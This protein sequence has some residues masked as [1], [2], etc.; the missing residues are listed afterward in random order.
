[1]SSNDFLVNALTLEVQIVY[2]QGVGAISVCVCVCVPIIACT[3]FITV[4]H[5]SFALAAKRH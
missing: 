2:T 4:F 3:L 5:I 1:M